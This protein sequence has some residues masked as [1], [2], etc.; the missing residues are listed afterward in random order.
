MEGK[1]WLPDGLSQGETEM[2]GREQLRAG[3]EVPLADEIRHVAAFSCSGR[4]VQAL[5]DTCGDWR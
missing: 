4:V 2:P 5:E 1:G 3:T